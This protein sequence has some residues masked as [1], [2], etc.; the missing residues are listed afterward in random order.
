MRLY[1]VWLEDYEVNEHT[2][3]QSASHIRDAEG[4]YNYERGVANQSDGTG[5]GDVNGAKGKGKNKGRNNKNENQRPKPEKKE[6]TEDQLARAVPRWFVYLLS[7]G[8]IC[9]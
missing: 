3:S 9:I 5:G 1:R 4:S 2:H 8:H 6:K 7:T